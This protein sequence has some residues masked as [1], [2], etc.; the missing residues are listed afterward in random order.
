VVVRE[1]RNIKKTLL[2]D[3]DYSLEE[4]ISREQFAN[5]TTAN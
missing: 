2:F 4:R 5:E 3:P 1:A